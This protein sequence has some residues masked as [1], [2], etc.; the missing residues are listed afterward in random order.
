MKQALGVAPIDVDYANVI[1][2][3]EPIERLVP[4][5][6]RQ[7]GFLTQD[8][9]NA[10]DT[11]NPFAMDPK[12]RNALLVK[13]YDYNELLRRERDGY[14]LTDEEQQRRDRLKEDVTQDVERLKNWRNDPKKVA[15]ARV[16][17]TGVLGA[18]A[19]GWANMYGCKF[20]ENYEYDYE[21]GKPTWGHD[22]HSVM[23][24]VLKGMAFAFDSTIGRA[25]VAMNGGDHSAVWFR[26]P[27]IDQN[28]KGFS[29]FDE[30]RDQGNLLSDNLTED[31]YGNPLP[32]GRSAGHEWVGVTFDFAMMST[33]KYLTDCGFD[34]F[35]PHS[36]KPFMDE[37][38]G[39]QPLKFGKWTV[40]KA[41]NG[42]VDVG[43]EWVAGMG[44][45]FATKQISKGINHLSEGFY[46]DTSV[47]FNASSLKVGDE[48]ITDHY[49]MAGIGEFWARFTS[50]NF[51]THTYRKGVDYIRSGE[52]A[53]D[54]GAWK[55]SGFH[56][57][58]P[59]SI[60]DST[61]WLLREGM[62]TGTYMAPAV[63]P[64]VMMRNPQRRF[65]AA[66]IDEN[67]NSQ[68]KLEWNPD[69][70]D[71][72][73]SW[74]YKKVHKYMGKH[75]PVKEWEPSDRAQEDPIRGYEAW[76]HMK[77]D[78]QFSG[79]NSLRIPLEMAWEGAGK[80]S[81][82][83]QDK[84]GKQY[85]GLEFMG[86]DADERARFAEDQVEA[87]LAY[88]P[89]LYTK[90]MM[91]KQF[92]TPEWDQR[93]DRTLKPIYNAI[94]FVTFQGG[95]GDKETEQA[96][97]TVEEPQAPRPE[98]TSEYSADQP[99][100]QTTINTRDLSRLAL[101]HDAP[102]LTSTLSR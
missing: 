15:M 93:F 80:A 49:G 25:V 8:S 100:P 16:I 102:E 84:L 50:Y 2:T 4:W 94:D 87:S 76:R 64:Y 91:I 30:L 13:E 47:N 46:Q 86:G 23:S 67:N 21:Q 44:Y 95:K 82:M 45:I 9:I 92:D 40:D 54:V 88:T 77:D 51:M 11:I 5:Q 90:E 37:E 18:A 74:R 38:K 29:N 61:K 1:N 27:W 36:E 3:Y 68:P 72:K 39:F 35:D 101:S 83:L 59:K 24:P 6:I 75:V 96:A 57:D 19:Y 41:V 34:L 62:K 66:V 63:V 65:R 7:Q 69:A 52:L 33:M 20:M 56:T 89:Y 31:P 58:I 26:E 73:G 17:G 32:G 60:A 55:D 99:S 12:A 70:N 85:E 28:G 53:N 97:K 22:N 79:I 14:S 42:V 78:G 48:G 43:Q 81:Y 71:G 10:L 98:R